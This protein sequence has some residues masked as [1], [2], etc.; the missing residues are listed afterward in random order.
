MGIPL[1]RF[2]ASSHEHK[3]QSDRDDRGLECCTGWIGSFTSPRSCPSFAS[4]YPVPRHVRYSPS[5]YFV[6]CWFPIARHVRVHLSG[7][8]ACLLSYHLIE[9][10][11]PLGAAHVAKKKNVMF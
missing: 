7:L 10:E 6:V 2:R 3:R 9:I 4:L 8:V 1:V 11:T 5:L